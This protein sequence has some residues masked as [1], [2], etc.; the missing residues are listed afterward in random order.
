MVALV[1]HDHGPRGRAGR[2]APD[3]E[4]DWADEPRGAATQRNQEE[5]HG[6]ATQRNP[7]EPRGGR[8]FV[9]ARAKEQG[10]SRSSLRGRWESLRISFKAEC[11]L[12]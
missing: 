3:V 8:K 12:T 5:A 1:K 4:R 9:K 6:R 11:P 2:K 7:D 10:I